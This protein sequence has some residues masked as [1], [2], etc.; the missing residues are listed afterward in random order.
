MKIAPS[1]SILS[2]FIDFVR[3]ENGPNVAESW[4]VSKSRDDTAVSEKV[5]SPG[6]TVA[7][8]TRLIY[9]EIEMFY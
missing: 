5:H 6:I 9:S 4:K 3:G 2:T 1:V 8:R 7:S